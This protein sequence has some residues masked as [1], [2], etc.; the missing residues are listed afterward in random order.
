MSYGASKTLISVKEAVTISI[1]SNI[2]TAIFMIIGI[3]FSRFIPIKVANIISGC[4]LIC[5]GIYLL[6]T[7]ILYDSKETI[8]FNKN[9][10]LTQLI[11]TSFG[12]S[13][14]NIPIA[15]SG[16]IAGICI[17]FVLAFSLIFSTLFLYFGNVAGTKIKSK[18]ISVLAICLFLILGILDI[19][20]I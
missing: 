8:K 5:L 18:H 6:F 16:G 10:S 11:M 1:L 2:V 3:T 4:L 19:F 7:E 17:W 13:I 20:L 9:L 12:L 15:V 14:N